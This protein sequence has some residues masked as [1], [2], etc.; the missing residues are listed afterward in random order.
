LLY[1]KY[2]IESAVPAFFVER[3]NASVSGFEAELGR[4]LN[5]V[6]AFL[7]QFEII[8]LGV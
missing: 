7:Y 8:S 6:G 3:I 2:I 5:T 1:K 4:V